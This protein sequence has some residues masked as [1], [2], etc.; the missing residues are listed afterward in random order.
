[1]PGPHR[2][3]SSSSHG[4]SCPRDAVQCRSPRTPNLS[5]TR[6]TQNATNPSPQPRQGHPRRKLRHSDGPG[7]ALTRGRGRRGRGLERWPSR[8]EKDQAPN[9][10]D[11]CSGRQRPS[12]ETVLR[13]HSCEWKKG[14]HETKAKT[15][16]TRQ[17]TPC[18]CKLGLSGDSYGV[19]EF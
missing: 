7:P 1:M 11:A 18:S 13:D 17:Y 14:N 15:H 5:S 6:K 3:R 9:T 10:K 19:M 4:L 16:F 8:R 2:A 12:P